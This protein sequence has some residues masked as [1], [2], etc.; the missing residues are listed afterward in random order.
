VVVSARVDARSLGFAG[1][2]LWFRMPAAYAPIEPR[3]EPFVVALLLPAMVAG[4]DLIVDGPLSP[5]LLRNLAEVQQ[6]L[7]G[8]NPLN[9]W[10]R[11]R[12]IEIRSAS[13]Q[14]PPAGTHRAGLFFSG[15]V[16]SM[17]SLLRGEAETGRSLHALVFIHGFDIPL[18]RV[19]R[20][21]TVLRHVTAVA[22]LTDRPLVRVA[23]NLRRFTDAA[24][25]WDM[26]HGAGLAAVGH[27]LASH[28]DCWFISASDSHFRNGE[29]SGTTTPLDRLW[30]NDQLRFLSVGASIDRQQK[31]DQ[32]ADEPC[33][34]RHLVVC[35]KA[36]DDILNCGRCAKCLR[37]MLNLL[38]ADALHK[39]ETLPRE[40][41]PEWLSAKAMGP[42]PYRV[43]HWEAMVQRLL[44]RPEWVPLVPPIQALIERSR[45]FR[46][47]PRLSD[48]R[49]DEGR[50]LTVEWLRRRL[51]RRLPVTLRRRILPVFRRWQTRRS[52]R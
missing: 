6:Y 17:Y 36:P 40:V 1:E 52:S 23:T 19:R 41:R 50:K 37:T 20:A 35:W 7:V 10:T 18:E 38:V 30:S 45:R 15:G 48:L 16:D 3:L 26:A 13:L 47:G 5:S 27:A 22:R 29:L 43:I 49:T 32:L 39:S 14:E 9:P 12:A 4:D 11:F 8:Q 33:V 44:S 24:L 28:F 46:E 51:R 2:Q 25:H 21:G 42:E 34:H 31:I